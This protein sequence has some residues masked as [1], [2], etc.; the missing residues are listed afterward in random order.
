MVQMREVSE[1]DRSDFPVVQEFLY[2]IEVSTHDRSFL[3]AVYK[4]LHG[5][6]LKI[7][8]ETRS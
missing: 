3:T 4:F 1:F 5:V 2:I 7:K 8:F 6:Y